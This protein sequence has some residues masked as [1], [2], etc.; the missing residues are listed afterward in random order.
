MKNVI[1]R[2]K[3]IPV[4]LETAKRTLNNPPLIYTETA[5]RQNPGAVALIKNELDS[6]IDQVP[7]MADQ[8]YPAQA[9]AVKALQE[10]GRWLEENLLP[11]SNGDFRLGEQKFKRKLQF[12]LNSGFVADQILEMAE[13]DLVE[14]QQALYET[15]LT[16]VDKYFPG[17]QEEFAQLDQKELCRRVLGRL[18]DDHPSSETVVDFARKTLTE[19]EDFVR[20]HDL[21]TMPT[22]P[23]E[24]IVMPEFQRGVA[25]AYCDSPGPFD[26]NGKTF[27]AIAPPSSDLSQKLVESR[28]REDNNYMIRDL[29]VHEAMPGHYLQA[30]HANK[31][32]APTMVRQ[33]FGS[34]PFVEGWAVYAEQFMAEA[35]FGGPE[36]KMQQLKMWLR[37]VTNTIIDHKIHAG[38]M[39]EEEAVKLMMEEGFQ[40]E[41]A[42]RGKWIRA[43]LTSTQLSTYYVG[44]LGIREAVRAYKEKYGDTRTVKQMHDDIIAF[45]SPPP[46]DLK[47]LL[48][49]TE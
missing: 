13:T 15:A 21:V 37:V 26:Q 5:I 24:I 43:Q 40:E 17:Q 22:E 1:A 12:T 30:M 25:I 33:I 39:T 41:Q 4:I 9:A 6:Y 38:S 2:L 10:F 20:A 23:I 46:K 11:R 44:A 47:P 29:T 3:E 32:K 48:G 34:G 49:L 8:V 16:L 18:A 19:A 45:G 28:F 31:F 42:A 7:F 27:Y 14:S 36:V 35:G